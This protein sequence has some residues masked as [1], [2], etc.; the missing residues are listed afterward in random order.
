[1]ASSTSALALSRSLSSCSAKISD[2]N[3]RIAERKKGSQLT[4]LKL[5]G[6]DRLLARLDLQC[7]LSKLVLF[8][9]DIRLLIEVTMGRFYLAR[10][11]I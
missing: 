7:L 4:K 10:H 6:L 11:H 5:R 2:L 8:T 3:A 1:M 9:S